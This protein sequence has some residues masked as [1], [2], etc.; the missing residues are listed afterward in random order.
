MN[1]VVLSF[2]MLLVHPTR[3]AR[4]CAEYMSVCLSVCKHHYIKNHTAKLYQ[5]LCTVF[6]AVAQSSSGGV[7]IR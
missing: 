5:I 6:V 3:G 2:S 1:G 4:Y 7:G